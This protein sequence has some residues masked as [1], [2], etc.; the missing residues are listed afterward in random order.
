MLAV[1]NFLCVAISGIVCLGLYHVAEETRVASV[2][3]HRVNHQISAEES[4]I[5]VL[6]AEW[7]RVADP[8]RIQKLAQAELDVTDTPVAELTSLQMLPRR[9]ADGPGNAELRSA[10]AKAPVQ[11]D[12]SRVRLAALHMRD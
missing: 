6:Q 11:D 9:N 12:A 2:E 3:L 4:A 10:S 7:A 5:T 8:A 1:L